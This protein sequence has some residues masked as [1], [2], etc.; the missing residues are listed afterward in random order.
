MWPALSEEGKS[1]ILLPKDLKNDDKIDDNDKDD[2]D[3]DDDDDDDD[4]NDGIFFFFIK[5][6]FVRILY[7]NL[8]YSD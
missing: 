4:N 2:D 8:H 3:N 6:F 5:P 1:L 7:L